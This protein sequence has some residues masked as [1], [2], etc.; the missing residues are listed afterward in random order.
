MLMHVHTLVNSYVTCTCIFH[1]TSLMCG[2][3]DLRSHER[4]DLCGDVDLEW[5]RALLL[6]LLDWAGWRCT[7]AVNVAAVIG[8]GDTTS[9]DA[10]AAEGRTATR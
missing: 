3:R 8:G 5:E 9:D 4:L 7:C 6:L 1:G 2:A 10:V